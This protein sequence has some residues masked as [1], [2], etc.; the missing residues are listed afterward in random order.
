MESGKIIKKAFTNKSEFIACVNTFKMN[1][2]EGEK[3]C[4]WCIVPHIFGVN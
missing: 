4:G 1:A 3:L 2:M